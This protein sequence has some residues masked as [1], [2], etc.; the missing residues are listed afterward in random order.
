[1]VASMDCS[2][3]LGPRVASLETAQESKAGINFGEVIVL[4]APTPGTG[5]GTPDHC[6]VIVGR[7]VF[8]PHIHQANRTNRFAGD[9]VTTKA[10]LGWEMAQQT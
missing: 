1:M 3:G 4:P 8:L 10:G 2:R 5:K 7:A 6:H 9:E